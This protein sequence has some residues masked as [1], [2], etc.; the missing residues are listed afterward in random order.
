VAV[1]VISRFDH[2][3][4]PVRDLDAALALWR[5]RL[6][7]DARPGGRHPGGTLNGIVRFGTDYVELISVYDR[8][9][10][11]ASGVADTRAVVDLLDRA[12]GGMLGFIAATDDMDAAADL[13]RSLGL[14]GVIGP[15]AMERR[16]PDGKLLR[17]RLL[18]PRRQAWGTPGTMLI[19][20]ELLDA[21]RL[22]WEQPGTH[23]N[24]AR[25]IV[26]VAVPVGEL[27]VGREIYERELGLTAA[28]EAAEP[29]LAARRVSYRIGPAERSIRIDLLSPTGTGPIADEVAAGREHLW[30]LTIGVADL[31]AARAFLAGRRVGLGAAPGTPGGLLIDPADALGARIVLVES[32]S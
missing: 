28:E 3:V 7:F 16:R 2:A 5:N 1:P 21:E 22:G 10:V 9:A 15:F 19:E 32:G 24:G 25:Q 17:W 11:L 14:S 30:Q 26:A 23:P 13:F 12:E 27:A 29:E 31:A 6:G 4:L 18:S 20:W 8:A